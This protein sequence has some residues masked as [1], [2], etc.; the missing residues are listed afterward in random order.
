MPEIIVQAPAGEP[1]NVEEA[2]LHMR[3]T[4]SSQDSRIR[5]L[6]AGAR[7]AAETKTRQQLLH[8][9]YRLVLDRFPGLMYGMPSAF[10]GTVNIP[11]F[12]IV[13]PHNPVI[14][15]VKIEYLDMDGTLQT[16][17]PSVYTLN[18]ALMPAIVTPRFGQIWPVPLPQVGAVMVTYD[19]G[20]AAPLTVVNAGA[21]T[22]TINS[23]VALA[24]GTVTRVYNSGGALPAGLAEATDYVIATAVAGVYTL[25][26]NGT[27]VA[28]T[29]TGSGTSYLGVVPEGLRNWILLRVGSMFENREE[30]AILNRGKIEELPFVDGL[31]DPYRISLP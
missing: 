27:P 17:D 26:R 5:S 31:L 3:V 23:P 24:V 20:Y 7:Q 22:L 28:F 25:T 1:I 4:E 30:V 8:A 11:G 14:A 12:A 15:V 19:A 6:I 29:D 13:L 2:K 9:R 18:N 21:G 10:S 16:V